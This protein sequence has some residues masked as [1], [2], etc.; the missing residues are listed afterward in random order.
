M[1]S[2]RP[3]LSN[4]IKDNTLSTES[5]QNKTLR[6]IIK[7]QHAILV[8]L[9]NNYLSNK[10]IDFQNLSINVKKDKIES[11]LQKDST[12]KKTIIG[13]IIGHFSNDELT[14]YFKNISEFDRRI[15]QI[16]AKRLQDSLDEIK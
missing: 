8:A 1:M 4:L 2:K 16:V 9:F 13:V 6:P 3:V 12:F 10:K 7:M 5:F 15:R 11:I 14:I